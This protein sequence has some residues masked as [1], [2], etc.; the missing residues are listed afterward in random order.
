MWRRIFAAVGL[1]SV[2]GAHFLIVGVSSFLFPHSTTQLSLTPVTRSR[3]FGPGHVS[4]CRWMMYS[5]E[6]AVSS[7]GSP[8]NEPHLVPKDGTFHPVGSLQE[9]IAAPVPPADCKRF[10]GI[11]KKTGG[12]WRSRVMGLVPS[13]V[14]KR[15]P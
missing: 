9:F 10:D 13:T 14:R 5:P 4:E 7:Y 2:L 11:G 1:S 8:V 3:R 6:K 12:V 15:P